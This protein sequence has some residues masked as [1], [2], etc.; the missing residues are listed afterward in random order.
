M[1]IGII[2]MGGIGS[3]LAFNISKATTHTVHAV[4]RKGSKRY[5]ELFRD[6]SIKTSDGKEAVVTALDTL[7]AHT[8][9]DLVIVTVK[10]YQLDSVLPMLKQS[11]VQQVVFMAN[12]FQPERMLNLFGKEKCGFAMPFLQ[13]LVLETGEL[14]SHD[15][16]SGKTKLDIQRW[17]DLFI[18]A[19]IPAAFDP[20]TVDFIR[21]HSPFCVAF[22]SAAVAG[23]K[24]G[25]GAPFSRC[26]ELARGIQEIYKVIVFEGYELYPTS[27]KVFANGPVVIPAAMLWLLTKIPSFRTLLASGREECERLIDSIVDAAL[28]NSAPVTIDRITAMKP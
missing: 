23:V 25:R 14:Q 1:N 13:A 21:S 3:A 19:G 22:Q 26:L 4:A 24:L 9:Y 18:Q 17:V 12:N 16:T 5:E 28:K 7:D 10:A 11:N 15:A 20:R 2:G 8:T 6:G 27:K